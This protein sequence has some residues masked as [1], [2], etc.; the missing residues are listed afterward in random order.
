MPSD[1]YYKVSFKPPVSPSRPATGPDGG[2]PNACESTSR[3]IGT[4]P[5]CPR[6]SI[7]L[8]FAGN[9]AARVD[10]LRFFGWFAHGDEFGGTSRLNAFVST[11]ARI[12]ITILPL[13]YPVVMH[14]PVQVS[15]PGSQCSN[16]C[17]WSSATFW[18]FQFR[19]WSQLICLGPR[20][21][22]V[23]LPLRFSESFW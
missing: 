4:F 11:H 15:A 5:E 12:F 17:S 2:Q 7:L 23:P 14:R 8:C 21:P 10:L 3:A 6:S 22:C 9:T 20:D 16:L 13:V 1:F 18:I 19:N